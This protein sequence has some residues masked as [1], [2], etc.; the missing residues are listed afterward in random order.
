M[1]SILGIHHGGSKGAIG[2]S[3]TGIRHIVPLNRA[4][5]GVSDDDFRRILCDIEWVGVDGRGRPDGRKVNGNATILYV[6]F[7]MGRNAY[8]FGAIQRRPR[9]QRPTCPIK[10]GVG[11]LLPTTY[12]FRLALPETHLIGVMPANGILVVGA[13]L[14]DTGLEF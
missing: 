7:G 14:I 5:A 10:R 4:V 2:T 12:L 9:M 3:R 1:D 8:V 6:E 13:F 11:S